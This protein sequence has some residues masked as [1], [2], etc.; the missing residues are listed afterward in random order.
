LSVQH[1]SAG[2]KVGFVVYNKADLEV[3]LRIRSA[4]FDII[5]FELYFLLQLEY[6][7]QL[8]SPFARFE[9]CRDDKAIKFAILFVPFTFTARKRDRSGR[10]GR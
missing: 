6:L 5:L 4:D 7:F 10:V 3:I 9:D 1:E 8:L 2:A